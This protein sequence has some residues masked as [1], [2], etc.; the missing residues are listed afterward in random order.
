MLYEYVLC[1]HTSDVREASQ[2]AWHQITFE[3]PYK[4]KLHLTPG[5][6]DIVVS[7]YC[8]ETHI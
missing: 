7:N 8:N 3:K 1:W 2:Y 4:K 6:V 5:Y